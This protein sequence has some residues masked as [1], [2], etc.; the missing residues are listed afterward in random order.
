MHRL[1][2]FAAICTVALGCGGS[3]QEEA[4]SSAGA[5]LAYLPADSGF[6][7]L[8]STDLDSDAW[9][10]LEKTVFPVEETVREGLE[11]EEE[12]RVSWDDDVKPLLGNDLVVGSQSRSGLFDDATGDGREDD[13]FIGALE[14][15]DADK[16]R[17]TLEKLGLRRAGEERGAEIWVEDES[18]EVAGIHS[19][20][21]LIAEDREA[22]ARAVERR[23][24]GGGLTQDLLDERLDALP[25]DAPV[26][27]FGSLEG[28]A[29]VDELAR[30]GK[31]PWVQALESFGFALSAGDDEVRADATINTNAERLGEDDLPLAT[32]AESPEVVA[33]EREISAANRDQ[34]RTTV[35]L[36]RLMRAA[37]PN[38]RFV[39]AVDRVERDLEI[40]FEDEVLRQFNGP[41]ASYVSPDGR[42]FAARSEVS[43]PQA[44]RRVLPRLA[45]HLPE[46]I[47]GLQGLQ[48]EGMALLF[49]FAPDAPMLASSGP[50]LDVRVH[51]PSTDDGLYRVTGLTGEGPSE[52]WFG[53]VDDVF[54]VAST[55]ERARE[56]AEADTQPVDGAQGAGV[57]RVDVSSVV[58]A[59]GGGGF[60][61]LTGARELRASVEAGTDRLHL[62][63]RLEVEARRPLVPFGS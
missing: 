39:E 60:L 29:E 53:V 3:E 11:E 10:A 19:D 44:L 21:L 35:F 1:L 58:D 9:N 13:D 8:V 24:D 15:A 26:R 30:F 61:P 28:V 17:D 40:D 45:P 49:L 14:V 4:E 27:V 46:L 55:E 43:D 50:L 25:G 20:V 31:V 38:S 16:L 56:I 41:S 2:V 47:N 51:R 23:E 42:T 52:M 54:V 18:S 63:L 57:M 62:R 33:R 36:L 34:S 6:V 12:G 37:Y 7:A 32:G 22:I 5:A 48:S 59:L